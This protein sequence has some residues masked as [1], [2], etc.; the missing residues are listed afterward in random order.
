M[1]R[2]VLFD[3]SLFADGD[4]QP[5]A[6]KNLVW[7]LEALVQR[8]MTYLT[9]HPNAP[10]LYQSGVRYAQ[11]AQFAGDIDEVAVLKAAL[12]SRK[13]D[14]KVAA[15]LDMVQAALGG[16]RFRDIGRVLEN[17]EADCDNLASWR[18]AELRQAGIKA[19]PY[20]TWRKRLDG[21]T[22]YHVVVRWPDDTLEDPSLLLGMGGAARARERQEQI[23]ANQERVEMVKAAAARKPLAPGIVVNES[24]ASDVEA[25]DALLKEVS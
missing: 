10:L 19:S 11:P 4:N 5:A 13:Y 25:I 16:E 14:S 18:A 6:R 2:F 8:D 17:G 20:I 9:D 24:P 12:G 1:L 7:I 21:G 23:D 22:T 15:A 3:L